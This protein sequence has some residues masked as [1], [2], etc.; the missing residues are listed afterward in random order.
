[1]HRRREISANETHASCAVEH[2]AEPF[3]EAAPALHVRA[4]RR[5][6]YRKIPD[7]TGFRRREHIDNVVVNGGR[8]GIVLT[9]PANLH[10]GGWYDR[11]EIESKVP[12]PQVRFVWPDR[13][14]KRIGGPAR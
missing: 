9:G 1:M 13:G 8:F 6:N 10:Y 7:S 4:S 3:F 2:R 5:Q 11:L 12:L 14:S